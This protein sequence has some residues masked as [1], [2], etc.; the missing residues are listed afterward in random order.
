MNILDLAA[1]AV[2]PWWVRVLPYVVA[3]ALVC[4]ALYAAYHHGCSVTAAQAQIKA[5]A[6]QLKHD[7]EII[8]WHGKVAAAEH[9]AADDMAAIDAQH[10][11]DM[12]NEKVTAA[13]SIACY[14]SGACRLR[15]QFAPRTVAGSGLPSSTTSASK[16]DEAATVGLQSAD[17]QFLISIASDADKVTDQ[18]R[19]CQAVVRADRAVQII[20]K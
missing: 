19:A 2:K 17:V 13:A 11:K 20:S 5:D 14:Q 16:R 7:A 10:Q 9:K 18:L 12:E 3:A 4:G 1:T 15:N 8:S 6:L